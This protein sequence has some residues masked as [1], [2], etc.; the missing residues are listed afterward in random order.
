MS[1]TFTTLE[2]NRP[3]NTTIWALN[4]PPNSNLII[5]CFIAFKTNVEN[6]HRFSGKL[7]KVCLGTNDIGVSDETTTFMGY[8]T[9]DPH[10]IYTPSIYPFLPLRCKD[11]KNTTQ[12][13][14]VVTMDG[15]PLDQNLVSF[16][17]TFRYVTEA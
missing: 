14:I 6:I 17:M 13:N 16:V 1:Q 3:P 8:S 10:G 11:A 7:V 12:L 9:F 5:P 15:Q 2:P 4:K